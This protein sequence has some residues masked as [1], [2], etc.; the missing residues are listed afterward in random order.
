MASQFVDTIS[1]YDQYHGHDLEMLQAILASLRKH[2]NNERKD[3][4]D[5]PVVFFAGDSSL[6][7][8]YWI[9]GWAKS[10]NG[11]E[12]ILRDVQLQSHMKQD[13][14]YWT[15]LE[16]MRKMPGTCALNT[17]VEAT[18]LRQRQPGLFSGGLTEQDELIRDEITENDYLVVSI[19]GND[20]ALSPTLSTIASMLAMMK[21]AEDEDLEE[22]SAWGFSHFKDLFGDQIQQYVEKLV[23]KRKPRRIL[24]CMIYYPDEA[25]QGSWADRALSA[26]DYNANPHRL[27]KAIASLFEQATKEI[28]VQGATIVPVP[29]FSVMNG[30]VT[31]DYVSRVEPSEQGGKKMAELLVAKLLE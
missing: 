1:F 13:V 15:N 17:S 21:F 25:G 7:N 3:Q 9:D 29:L 28:Q 20:I 22:G 10:V 12:D 6:D 2:R 19:G 30:K 11:Y 27:Q 8:K 5:R 26:L 31:D 4:S 24:I 18:T 16:L 14:S 23:S